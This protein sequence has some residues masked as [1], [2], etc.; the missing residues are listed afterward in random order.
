MKDSRVAR[1]KSAHQ[2]VQSQLKWFRLLN[3]ENLVLARLSYCGPIYAVELR[4]KVMLYNK[5]IDPIEDAFAL[6]VTERVGSL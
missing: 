3:R 6:F 4:V 5:M 1:S 2:G